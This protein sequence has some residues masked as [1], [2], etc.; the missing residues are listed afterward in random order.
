MKATSQVKDQQVLKLKEELLAEQKKIIS[1]TDQFEQQQ[2]ELE[3][4]QQKGEDK[5]KVAD[6]DDYFHSLQFLTLIFLVF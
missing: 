2:K 1:L 6:I 4:V 3:M 5:V